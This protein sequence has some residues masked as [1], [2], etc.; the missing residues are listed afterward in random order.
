[1]KYAQIRKYD[2]A[3]GVG[4]RTSVFVSGCTHNC[5]N[6]FNKDYQN[7]EYGNEFTQRQI[8][9]IIS[10]MSEDEIAG[11][12][13]LGGEPLQQNYD[14][15]I[16]FLKQVRNATKKSIWIYS[17]YTFEEISK[18]EKKMEVISYCDVL[19]DGRYE[20][21]LRNLRL[22]FRGSSNQRI[23]DIQ[24]TLKEGKLVILKGFE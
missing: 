20:E 1:M 12:T 11:L 6:C 17:G 16:D 9:E 23:I 14:D 7:F 21:K 18:C 19:V 3:N 5:F 15:M 10:Y 2:I 22:K 4:I 24:R 8:D 13:I